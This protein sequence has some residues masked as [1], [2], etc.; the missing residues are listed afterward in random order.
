LE[1]N[2]NHIQESTAAPLRF[3]S[4]QKGSIKIIIR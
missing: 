4:C 3:P 1:N 2:L